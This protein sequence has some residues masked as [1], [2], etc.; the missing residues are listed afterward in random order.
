M[1]KKQSV[2]SS[3]SPAGSLPLSRVM[4]SPTLS[5]PEVR[6]EACPHDRGAMVRCYAE[7]G[8]VWRCVTCGYGVDLDLRPPQS[9]APAQGAGDS[10]GRR[11][12]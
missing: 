11:T 5:R 4:V 3:C 10:S 7:P 6:F 12:S 9:P 8:V 1:A 2:H